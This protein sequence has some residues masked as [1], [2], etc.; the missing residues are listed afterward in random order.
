M[1]RLLIAI[2]ITGLLS[3]CVSIVNAPTFT[4][5]PTSTATPTAT[6]TATSTP[7]STATPT[8]TATST[9]TPTRTFTPTP[10]ATPVGFYASD[11]GFSFILPTNWEIVDE[12][13]DLVIIESA[14]GSTQVA[15][16]PVPSEEYSST[17]D[18]I[19]SL[20]LGILGENATYTID[21]Q[22]QI[23][24]GDGSAAERTVFT[25]NLTSTQ[26]FQGEIAANQHGSNVYIF[27]TFSS[28]GRLSSSQHDT[29]TNL[30]ASINLTPDTI[31]GLARADS[32]LLLGYDPLP[33]DLDPALAQT[34]PGDYIGLL[35]SGL[36]RLTSDMQVVGDLAESWTTSADGLVYTFTLRS[37][38]SFQ[39]GSPLTA[40]DVKYSWER[41]ADAATDSPTALT[42]LGDIVGFKAMHD[43]LATDVS[44]IEVIDDVTLQVTLENPVQSFLGKLTYPT[45]FVIDQASVEARPELWMYHPN[46]SGPY[47]LKEREAYE[48]LIFERNEMYYQPALIPYVIYQTDAPGTDLSYYQSGEADIVNPSFTDTREIQDPAHALHDQL[49]MGSEMCTRF[50]MLN[51][52]MQPMEDANV[53]KALS[54]AINKDY[55]V[56]QFLDNMYPRADGIL[57]PGMP[58]FAEVNAPTYDPQAAKEALAASSYAGKMPTL[59]LS[60]SGYAGDTND[61]A[62]ALIQ[63]WRDVLGIEVQIEYL[64]PLEF[65]QAAHDGH[66][67]MVIFGW[68]ADYPD[69]SNFLD[70]LFHTD[71][72][73][74]VSGYTNPSADELL[75]QA[76]IEPD[77][78]TRLDL[79]NQ[80]ESK[81]LDDYATIP[82]NHTTAYVL[83][84]PRVKGFL[85]TP[86]GV[87]LI[88][89]LWLEAP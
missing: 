76:R 65:T 33:E 56:E 31:Y 38:L 48:W 58:G 78:S 26:T 27:V 89:Y 12:S 10:T 25:C 30:Y 68:C 81:L 52:T 17:E 73:L 21:E 72:D 8:L 82:I 87:K 49:L 69:P 50:I 40:D 44:G 55:M 37:G 74:N 75:D 36:V 88:P 19:S 47:G 45:S 32:L 29:L 23:T 2:L 86:I 85:V 22:E 24:F 66:G 34:S 39:D 84:N 61:W 60:I 59:T 70:I 62:D 53:R 20:C 57:P 79:Y 64:D 35:Y 4:P 41:A 28:T 46:A 13:D 67:Q 71:S 6:A 5:T 80:V 54:L 7:T 3:G 16:G 15:A 51:N 43:R 11:M 63:M 1:K 77:Q 9:A 42:Y 14:T 83:V 18:F